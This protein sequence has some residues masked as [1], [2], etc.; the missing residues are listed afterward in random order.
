GPFQSFPGKGGPLGFIVYNPSQTDPVNT[1]DGYDPRSGAKYFASISSYSGP[2]NDWLISDE[3]ATHQGGTFSFYAKSAANFSGDDEFKVAYSMTAS[4]PA[5][6]TYLNGGATISPSLNWAKF[7]YTIPAGAKHIAINCVS[8]AF[9]MLV[10][11]L[12]FAPTVQATAPG[13][14]TEFSAEAQ[15]DAG[16]EA[17][18]NWVNPTI[19][20]AGNPLANMTGEIG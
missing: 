14:I 16:I 3:L 8:Y 6:F 19:D 17:V 12:E 1:L 9:M 2:S 11:D 7:E 4:D 5:D 15:I 20:F 18:F 10:D 13:I